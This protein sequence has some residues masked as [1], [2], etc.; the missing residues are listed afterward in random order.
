MTDTTDT[1]DA[2]DTTTVVNPEARQSAHAALDRWL[3]E[4]QRESVAAYE[5][6][7]QGYIGRIKFCAFVDDNGGSLSVERSFES[8]L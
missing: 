6:G 4:C 7:R 1:A 2:T 8:V 3:D 5:G